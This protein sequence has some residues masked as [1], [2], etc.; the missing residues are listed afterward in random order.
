MRWNLDPRSKDYDAELIQTGRVYLNGKLTSGVIY[1]DEG[2]GLAKYFRTQ[3]DGSF[4][5]D[6]CDQ[7]PI[8]DSFFGKVLI[9]APTEIR[10]RLDR[11]AQSA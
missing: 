6:P 3:N 8:V 2:T 7:R 1:A 5:I 9:E 11:A 10:Q 4:V